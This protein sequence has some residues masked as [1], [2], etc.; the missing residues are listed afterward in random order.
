MTRGCVHARRAAMFGCIGG[1]GLAFVLVVSPLGIGT[2]PGDEPVAGHGDVE[3]VEVVSRTRGRLSVELGTADP[4]PG[5][6]AEDPEGERH[7]EYT[8]SDTRPGVPTSA[9]PDLESP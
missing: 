2:V 9:E 4:I 5:R 7:P 6:P 3:L 8:G 1:E